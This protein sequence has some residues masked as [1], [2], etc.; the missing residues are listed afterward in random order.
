MA[1][2][3]GRL[4]PDPKRPPPSMAAALET[5]IGGA[6]MGSPVPPRANERHMQLRPSTRYVGWQKGLLKVAAGFCR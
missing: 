5:D 3:R 6:W 2:H 4:V 1:S